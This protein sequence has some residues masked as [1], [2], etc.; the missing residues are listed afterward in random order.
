MKGKHILIGFLIISLLMRTFLATWQPANAGILPPHTN[1]PLTSASGEWTLALGGAGDEQLYALDKTTDGGLVLAGAS[2]SFTAGSTNAWIIKQ[3]AW[4]NVVWQETISLNDHTIAAAIAAANDGYLAAGY[5]YSASFMDWDAWV[6]KFNSDGSLVWQ[7]RF[8]GPGLDNPTAIQETSDGGAIVAGWTSSFSAGDTDLWLLKLNGDGAV[9]WENTVGDAA[10]DYANAVR[11]TNDGGYIVA[12]YTY[13]FGS[14]AADAWALKFDSSGAV[15]WQKSYGGAGFDFANDVEQTTDGGYILIGAIFPSLESQDSAGWIVKLDSDGT[16][17][18]QKAVGDSSSDGL[19]AVQETASGRY[20][21]AGWTASFGAGGTDLWLLE[22]NASGDIVWQKTYGQAADD[23]GQALTLADDGGLLAAGATRS[24]GAGGSDFWLLKLDSQGLAENCALAADSSAAVSDTTVTAT[25][26]NGVAQA[27]VS[28]VVSV[29]A[30][31]QQTEAAGIPLCRVWPFVAIYA[32]AG[33]NGPSNPANLAPYF[34]P[35]MDNFMAATTGKPGI[36]VI[37][38]ADLDG[39]GDTVIHVIQNGID[40]PIDGLPAANGALNVSRDEYNM[41]N[42]SDLG[43]FLLWAQNLFPGNKTL[44]SFIG[45]S[46]FLAP[47]VSDVEALFP[48]YVSPDKPYT[49]EVD[50]GFTDV[51][52]IGFVTPYALGEALRTGTQNGADPIDVLDLTHC[53]AAS[54]EE[55]YEAAPYAEVIIGS[56]NYAYSAADMPAA[57]LAAIDPDADAGAIA[58]ALITAYDAVLN[59]ADL[60][61]GDPDAEHPRIMAAVANQPLLAFKAEMDALSSSLLQAFDNDPLA[62]KDDLFA[63]YTAT[64]S[65]YDTTFCAPEWEMNPPDALVDAAPFLQ[66]VVNT[67]GPATEIGNRAANALNLVNGAIITS[68]ARSGTPWF[69]AP[70]TPTWMLTQTNRIGLAVYA[71][72][73]GQPQDGGDYVNVPLTT[74]FYTDSFTITL[75]LSPTTTQTITNPHPYGFVQDGAYGVTWA[76]VLQRYWQVKQQ[77]DNTTL[78]TRP[79]LTRLPA[80]QQ[81]GELSVLS[82]TSPLSGTVTVGQPVVPGVE[83]STD[84]PALNP[85]VTF[86]IFLEGI[87]VY[88]HSVAAGYLLTGTHVI[89]ASEAWTPI[90]AGA[91]TMTV[92]V[93]A[94]HRFWE[95]NESDN[96]LLFADDVFDGAAQA[97]TV[98]TPDGGQWLDSRQ[99]TLAIS[100]TL[101]VHALDIQVYDY[102]PGTATPILAY[103]H[104]D[105]APVLSDHNY[106]FTLPDTVQPGPLTLHVWALSNGRPTPQP[107]V[108][109]LNYAPGDNLLGTGSHA[110]RLHLD[111]GAAVT[112]TLDVLAGAAQL[113]I[114]E[115]HNFWSAHSV[116]ATAGI[117]QTL[118]ISPTRRGEYLLLVAGQEPETRY[119]LSPAE[120]PPAAVPLSFYDLS[121]QPQL[122]LSFLPPVPQAAVYYCVP[123]G[124]NAGSNLIAA[125]LQTN[126][127]RLAALFP[128]ALPLYGLLPGGVITNTLQTGQGYLVT[129]DAPHLYPLCGDLVV[130][131]SIPVNA[132]WN[133][134]GIFDH[135]VLV[136]ALA[137]NPPGARQT[138]F[139]RLLNDAWS[140]VSLLQPGTGYLVRFSQPATLLLSA[141][142]TIW[143]AD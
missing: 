93:D 96:S 116:T 120:M 141:E 74:S 119:T 110:Y 138:Q 114:W 100:S 127:M 118:I 98:T 67:F 37:F 109:H 121:S 21:T 95:T 124:V 123:V 85:L 44:F 111:S 86:D 33:D 1:P 70:L 78:L 41:T 101:P 117:S 130:S 133:F 107:S 4:G 47:A 135:P 126:D 88:A 6:V 82:V 38:L 14:S 81:E 8:S 39:Q 20:L 89:A 69:A 73:Q 43:G 79:C 12:G 87:P 143:R 28:S 80:S 97:F 113:S 10:D 53:F 83:I 122:R 71:D 51:H 129:F 36:V 102:A 132:G 15:V 49:I 52:P 16:I 99:I 91:Y 140:P 103:H 75:N 18:W 94:D 35:M 11:Q 136:A 32:L 137:T 9:A 50:P 27:V 62:T 134:I 45:H 76:D 84:R 23:N 105:N 3:D 77:Q 104:H 30:M 92:T 19:Q 48:E 29:N 63:A 125:P 54:V 112:M 106:T 55:F 57:A 17:I 139:F 65:Y 7:Y 115:P 64:G 66:A 42:G 58:A 108:L 13:S 40:T 25:D 131:Q 60:S 2:T 90:S 59:Q 5:S 24:V 142:A 128:D 56:P 22:L 68:T 26:T 46:T 72:M 34:Q 61:D 31:V